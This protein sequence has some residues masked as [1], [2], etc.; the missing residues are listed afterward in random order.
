[1]FFYTPHRHT[2]AGQNVHVDVP[3][4][5]TGD[6]VPHHKRT[7]GPQQVC[8]DVHSEDSIREKKK[9]KKKKNIF[10]KNSHQSS[11]PTQKEK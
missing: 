4:C 6:L 10:L 3:P 8:V 5:H 11:H 2:V 7:D 1:M 9:K